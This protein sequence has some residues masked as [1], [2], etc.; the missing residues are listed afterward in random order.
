M[1]AISWDLSRPLRRYD[2]ELEYIP[3]QF[4]CEYI[5]F[6]T[7]ADGIQF[8]SSLEKDGVNIVLF[9]QENIRCIEVELHQITEVKIKSK[10]IG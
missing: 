7:K 5:R 1:D 9:N 8:F 4:I 10:R 6:F 2:S 3:T